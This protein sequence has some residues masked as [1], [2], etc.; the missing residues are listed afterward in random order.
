M[1]VAERRGRELGRSGRVGGWETSKGGVRFQEAVRL[2]L[3]EQ[4]VFFSRCVFFEVPHSGYPSALLSAPALASPR[5]RGRSLGMAAVT[6]LL[7]KP[8]RNL[9]KPQRSRCRGRLE[10]TCFSVGF[11]LTSV[12]NHS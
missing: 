11:S 3:S 12:A 9:H 4:L 8:Y 6:A 1:G 10:E 7:D 2:D 5:A